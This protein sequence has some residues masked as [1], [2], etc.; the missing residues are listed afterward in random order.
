MF[1]SLLTALCFALAGISARQSTLHSGP[2]RANVG[3]LVLGLLVLSAVALLRW[4][5]M[6]MSAVLRFA[7]A[8][9]IGFGIGGY[10]MMLTLRRLGT[11]SALLLVESCTA[12][13]AGLLAWFALGDVLTISQILACLTILAG[14]LIAGSGWIAE[15]QSSRLHE[16]IAG[17]GFGILA[18]AS[19]AVSLVLSR[20]VF[21]QTTPSGGTIDKLD[22][23]WIR[24]IGGAFVA[25]L[26]LFILNRKNWHPLDQPRNLEASSFRW[27]RPGE[28]LFQQP[29]TWILINA[30]MGPV[31]GVTCWLWA[32]SLLNPG[33]V[34]SI[35]AIAP[36]ISLPIARWLEREPIGTAF[37]IGAP[38]AILGT[39]LLALA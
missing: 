32:V 26:F 10:C 38:V 22:A 16:R 2:L 36:L 5:G 34:Q 27:I 31:L 12:V 37:F 24:L 28:P 14:V 15:S 25:S 9:A 19:Q 39:A 4:Q 3:R 33:I 7:A 13:L 20:Q 17:Y 8:G 1:P 11:P 23:A 21:L 30:L 18:S 6:S 29:F 35:A